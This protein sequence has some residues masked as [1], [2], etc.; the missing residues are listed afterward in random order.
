[1]PTGSL[2]QGCTESQKTAVPKEEAFKRKRPEIKG[3]GEAKSADQEAKA[4][5]GNLSRTDKGCSSPDLSDR[6]PGPPG[7]F[8]PVD[9]GAGSQR[10]SWNRRNLLFLKSSRRRLGPAHPHPQVTSGSVSRENGTQCHK[11]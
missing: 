2:T 8:P 11:G 10:S 3:Q 9:S 1:M 6:P 7:R 5:P 4:S